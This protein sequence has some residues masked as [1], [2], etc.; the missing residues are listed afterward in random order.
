[1]DW[2]LAAAEVAI[3]AAFNWCGGEQPSPGDF[4]PHLNPDDEEPYSDGDAA[5]SSPSAAILEDLPN[6]RLANRF[7]SGQWC[8]GVPEAS[9]QNANY[10]CERTAPD[11]QNFIE[12]ATQEQIDAAEEDAE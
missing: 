9:P 4:F 2:A 5:S 6:M 1:M 3:S 8:L 7:V 10:V 11:P 12:V